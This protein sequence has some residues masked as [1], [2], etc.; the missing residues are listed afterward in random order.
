MIN[1]SSFYKAWLHVVKQENT[2]ELL[3]NTWSN[4]KNFT[5]E[6]IHSKEAVIQKVANEIKLDCYSGDYYSLDAVFYTKKDLV[7]NIPHNSC[8]LKEI[9][10]AF[11]HEN[12]FNNNLYQEVAHLLITRCNLKVL[13]SYPNYEKEPTTDYLH[14]IISSCSIA[15]EISEKE[16]FLLILGYYSGGKCEW[17]GWVYKNST[18]K[19]KKIKNQI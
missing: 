18:E 12:I 6:I 9:Q 17:E 1:S 7:S 3:R 4:N 13:V 15:Q 8:W 19:W 14:D 5:H 16:N 10:I 2:F 11:E